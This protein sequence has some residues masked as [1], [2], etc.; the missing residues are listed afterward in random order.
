MSS[1]TSNNPWPGLWQ[2]ERSVSDSIKQDSAGRHGRPSK[3]KVG[4]TVGKWTLLK[5]EP[6]INK[7]K[8]VAAYFYCQCECG[9]KRW[10][11]ASNLA[12]GTTKSCGC[13]NGRYSYEASECKD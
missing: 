4:D 12:A 13:D 3:C 2:P 11:R 1:S 10:V 5:Y 6:G 7:P 8:R 9:T